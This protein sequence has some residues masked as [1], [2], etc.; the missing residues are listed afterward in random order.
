MGSGFGGK[1]AGL[2]RRF[3]KGG[4]RGGEG[5]GGGGGKEEVEPTT[6]ADICIDFFVTC[7][8]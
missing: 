8:L 1:R 6:K 4:A 5:G 2:G 7:P 3:E